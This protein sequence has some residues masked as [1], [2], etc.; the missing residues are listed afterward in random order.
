VTPTHTRGL[1]F[2][3]RTGA[4]LAVLGAF[5]VFFLA[6]PLAGL[7]LNL[8]GKDLADTYGDPQTRSAVLTSLGTASTSTLIVGAFG[9]PLAYVLARFHFPG[10]A[11]VTV[12]VFLPL[13]LPPVSAGIL[14]L[15]LYG[16]EGTIG[17]LLSPHGL[18]F[19]DTASGIVLAQV[20]V[21]A[22]FVIVAA[23][24]AFEGLDMEYEEAAASMGASL[25]QSFRHVA[26]PMARGGIMAGLLLGWMRSL[27][28][29]GAT[30]ILAYHP[31]SLPV[32]NYV[33]LNST[34]LA[35]A[36]PLALLALL[37]A[38]AVL[39]VLFFLERVGLGVRLGRT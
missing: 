32:L 20:F 5:A 11:V 36:L 34:G 31:Y 8:S 2:F 39:V 13:V 37:L 17:G 35:A 27:G 10:R 29:F 15:M 12:L 23:R 18:L 6:A 7:L 14:L 25:W 16:P 19:T 26:V 33:N 28:E 9:V 24:A 4:P 22:P 21:S 3:D 1:R 38:G 30:I